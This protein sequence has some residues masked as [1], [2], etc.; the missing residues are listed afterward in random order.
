MTTTVWQAKRGQWDARVY[1]GPRRGAGYQ[2]VLFEQVTT[3]NGKVIL[4]PQGSSRHQTFDA[5][6]QAADQLLW[7]AEHGGVWAR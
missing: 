7:Q 6:K 2:A 5:A 1:R 3:H 4:V